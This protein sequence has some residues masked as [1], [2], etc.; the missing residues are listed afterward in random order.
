MG[1]K[2]CMTRYSKI[3][4][5][6]A[7]EDRL[8]HIPE[9]IS[10]AMIDLSS[11][12]YMALEAI[13]TEAP[14]EIGRSGYS[15]VASRLLSR[16]QGSHMALEKYL[17]TAYGKPSLLFNSG[18]HANTGIIS[19]LAVEGTLFV[20]D[21]LIHAS[22]IDGLRLS[23]AP[24][25]RFRHNDISHLEQILEKE[26]SGYERIILLTESVFSMD[27]DI[28]PIEGIVALKNR[29]PN[30]LVYLD[31]A[32]AL[33]VRG[34]KGLGIAEETG[35][36]A[37]ID[38]LIG[39]LGKGVASFGAFVICD[40]VIK[41]F[42]INTSRPL[43]FSTALPP[44]CSERTLTNLRKLEDM[45]EERT[46]LRHISTMLRDLLEE[47]RPGSTGVTESHIVPYITG[48]ARKAVVMAA[49]LREKGFDAL[50]I[51]RPTVP[52]GTERIRFS[53]NSG[54]TEKD[55]TRLAEAIRE[56]ESELCD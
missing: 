24:Y 35:H 55:I 28:A 56:I 25:K 19:A 52:P 41:E 39:T 9:E 11:N 32:H 22:M 47:I 45:K 6:L 10:G 36:L 46:H 51:R 30:L 18:Y 5:G 34:E 4:D 16:K 44:I 37:D 31:E 17:E 53:L 43:I 27:G 13:S 20:A 3:L 15:S 54:L 8:R 23:G 29:F 40:K 50:P 49:R 21:K 33:G 38:I 7:A 14:R 26:A 42:L 12:D 48:D 1:T 2:E